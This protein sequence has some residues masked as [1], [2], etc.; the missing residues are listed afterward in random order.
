MLN[1]TPNGCRFNA[2]DDIIAG[3]SHQV[4]VAKN[5]N[6]ALKDIYSQHWLC[7]A[8]V[9]TLTLR[10]PRTPR[11]N[12]CTFPPGRRPSLC[13][14]FISTPYLINRQSVKRRGQS[15]PPTD[16]PNC[17]TKKTEPQTR[18]IKVAESFHHGKSTATTGARKADQQR[19]VD[20]LAK[21]TQVIICRESLPLD[22][23]NR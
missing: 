6:I 15:K 19:R 9:E 8:Q 5:L 4:A 20:T 18:K 16:W 12:H 3:P 13:A 1:H 10:F 22:E 2:V 23:G 17:G 7:T 11:L 14:S 21:C